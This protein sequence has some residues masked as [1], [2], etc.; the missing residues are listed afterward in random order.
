[1][2]TAVTIEQIGAMNLSQSGEQW[3]PFSAEQRILTCRPGFVWDARLSIVPGVA[4]HVHDAYVAGVGILNPSVLG[5]YSLADQRGEGEI[6]RGELIRYFAEAA[7]YPTAMLPSQGVQWVAVDADSVS[8]TLADGSLSV[9]MLVRFNEWGLIESARFEA[10]GAIVDGQ[11]VQ[12][13]WEG[14][15]SNYEEHDGMR[16]PVTGEAAWLHPQVRK[17]YWRGNITSLK[18]EF[19]S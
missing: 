3:K 6:A 19:S 12:I 1:M 11:T 2:V 15:W 7:W 5:L 10:R 8:A 13:P 14:R 4:V 18:Y 16:V 9:T 17:P